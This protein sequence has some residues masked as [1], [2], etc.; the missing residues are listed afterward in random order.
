MSNG[1]DTNKLINNIKKDALKKIRNEIKLKGHTV[2]CPNCGKPI[3]VKPPRRHCPYC[4][5]IIN[6]K[7]DF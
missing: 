5:S 7:I 3:K 4:R 2:K 1:L 6:V